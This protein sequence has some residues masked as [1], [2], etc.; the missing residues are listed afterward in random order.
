MFRTPSD[1][2]VFKKYF[3]RQVIWPIAAVVV[4]L[5]IAASLGLYWATGKSD[6]VALQRQTDAVQ[7]AIHNSTIQLAYEQGSIARWDQLVR[8]VGRSP[9]DTA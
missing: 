1:P 3:I 6:E 7:M 5:L 9:V 8:E 2:V 4:I